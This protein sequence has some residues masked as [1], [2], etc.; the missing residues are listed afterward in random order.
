MPCGKRGGEGSSKTTCGGM[1]PAE[2]TTFGGKEFMRWGNLSLIGG[3][4]IG[5]R[6]GL[7]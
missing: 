1:E 4:S 6:P 7:W 5:E 3:L 2:E